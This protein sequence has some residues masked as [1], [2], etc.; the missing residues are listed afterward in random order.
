MFSSCSFFRFIETWFYLFLLR[1]TLCCYSY[2]LLKKNL[3]LLLDRMVHKSFLMNWVMNLVLMI[4]GISIS[5]MR[6]LGWKQFM[7]DKKSLFGKQ[8]LVGY[9]LMFSTLILFLAT[10]SAICRIAHGESMVNYTTKSTCQSTCRM[11]KK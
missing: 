3:L 6:F 2:F 9:H 7:I 11:N 8:S 5:M 1:V 10:F 4:F